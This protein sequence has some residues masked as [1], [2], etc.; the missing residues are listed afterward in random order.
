MKKFAYKVWNSRY[1][2]YLLIPLIVPIPLLFE[3]LSTGGL[4]MT[5]QN[6]IFGTFKIIVCAYL[7]SFVLFIVNS[8]RQK[9][10]A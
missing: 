9:F 7:V 1:G 5:A 2:K 4:I 10:F 6:L 8:A 3:G